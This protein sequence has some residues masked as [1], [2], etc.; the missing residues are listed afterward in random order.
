MTFH[1]TGR[2]FFAVE[3][4]GFVN[5]WQLLRTQREIGLRDEQNASNKGL[6]SNRPLGL[7]R[8][9]TRL[10]D[11]AM[12]ADGETLFIAGNDG[13]V[14]GAK[15]RGG[16]LKRVLPV[17]EDTVFSAN[18]FELLVGPDLR[19]PLVAASNRGQQLKILCPTPK[20]FF[21]EG[22]DIRNLNVTGLPSA[23]I[24]K[25]LPTDPQPLVK[26]SSEDAEASSARA[27]DYAR[28]AGDN[29]HAKQRAVYGAILA[30]TGRFDVPISLVRSGLQSP[31]LWAAQKTGNLML[32]DAR[33]LR[34]DSLWLARIKRCN[35]ISQALNK[36][37]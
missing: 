25:V 15:T 12:S 4:E 11:M 7:L 13:K 22:F 16:K 9:Y 34:R 35:A 26:I 32:F 21:Q 31:L 33:T 20:K 10:E 27:E 24:S 6:T 37:L 29:F 3:Q 5:V 30:E 18:S 17:G 28:K 8:L 14:Y 1:P 36:Q 2:A 23:K 19:V